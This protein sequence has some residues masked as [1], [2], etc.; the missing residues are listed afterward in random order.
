MEKREEMS[1][2][3]ST[4]CAKAVAG[5]TDQVLQLE[6]EKRALE[7]KLREREETLRK[8]RMVKMYQVKNNLQ[9]LSALTAKWRNVAQEAAE[10]LL[11][12]S[13]H[14]PRP[15]MSQMLNYLHIDHE[16]IHYSSQDEAFY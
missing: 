6:V 10:S 5:S 4:H 11:E 2:E 9:D 7:A 14:E 16:L 12:S 3:D 15:T 8:L 13:T 1:L